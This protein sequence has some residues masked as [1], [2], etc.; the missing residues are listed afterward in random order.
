MIKKPNE[1]YRFRLDL[2][3]INSVIKKD[4]YPV[5]I[6][7]TIL[8]TLRSPRYISWIDLHS[9]YNQKPLEI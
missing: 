8:D 9:A 6:M 7:V 1:K 2:R 3:K 4:L 5:P